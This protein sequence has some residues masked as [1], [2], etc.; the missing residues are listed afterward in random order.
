MTTF[1]VG[2]AHDGNRVA[3][4]RKNRP[5]DQA[6][7][8]NGIGGKIEPGEASYDAMVREFMEETG[9]VIP[10]W[11]KVLRMCFT[12][13]WMDAYVSYVEPHVL[14]ELCTETDE[15][16]IVTDI[17]AV[18]PWETTPHLSWLLPLAVSQEKIYE[19]FI[20]STVNRT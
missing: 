20:L 11:R 6:G 1:V 12:V 10:A 13:G 2:F 19:P 15:E 8:L 17:H 14:N 4:I 9:V 16:V 18:A 5:A 7:K 3:L